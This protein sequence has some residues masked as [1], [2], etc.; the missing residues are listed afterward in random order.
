MWAVYDQEIDDCTGGD[1]GMS[2]YNI[3]EDA[4]E[5][6][7][8]SKI[9]GK[10]FTVLVVPEDAASFDAAVEKMARAIDPEG[11]KL[12]ENPPKDTR[13]PWIDY[14]VEARVK[15]RA[16]MKSLGARRGK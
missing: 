10:A 13:V 11:F 3:L 5:V 7:R 8:D 16:A 14:R 6:I 1:M 4:I 15:A 12:A 9:E 2:V